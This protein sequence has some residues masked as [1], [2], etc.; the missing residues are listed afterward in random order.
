MACWITIIKVQTINTTALSPETCCDTVFLPTPHSHLWEQQT[1]SSSPVSPRKML[2]CSP[3]NGQQLVMRV[4]LLLTHV[5]IRNNQKGWP[6]DRP[7]RSGGA[8]GRWSART[9]GP[10]SASCPHEAGGVSWPQHHD[11]PQ[12]HHLEDTRWTNTHRIVILFIEK[13]KDN[14]FLPLI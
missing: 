9:V 3:E 7:Q 12:H 11:H 1:P 10:P 8:W 13:K 4:E 14:L 6:W 5:N 2:T